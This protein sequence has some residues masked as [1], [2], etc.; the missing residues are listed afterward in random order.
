[1]TPME[2]ARK[3][4]DGPHTCAGWPVRAT[5]G[6]CE[7][8]VFCRGG[9]GPSDGHTDDCPIPH[10]PSIVAALEAAPSRDDL[11]ELRYDRKQLA[12]LVDKVRRIESLIDHHRAMTTQQMHDRILDILRGGLCTEHRREHCFECTRVSISFAR[13]PNP[14]DP[15]DDVI[16]PTSV[17][18]SPNAGFTVQRGDCRGD[19]GEN[20]EHLHVSGSLTI[21]GDTTLGQ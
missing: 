7:R 19:C 12:T 15:D 16:P 6:S 17:V 8:C 11:A 1:M 9:S 2:A 20:A 14:D 10:L 21:S 18:V 5:R 3:L 4:Q 13:L